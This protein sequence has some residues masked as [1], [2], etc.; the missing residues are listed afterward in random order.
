M[1]V[2]AHDPDERPLFGAMR[3]QIQ[4]TQMPARPPPTSPRGSVHRPPADAGPEER[5]PQWQRRPQRS[6]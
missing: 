1:N 5:L 4:I 2:S 3:H 6:W